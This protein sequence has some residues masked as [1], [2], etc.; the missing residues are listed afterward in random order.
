MKEH[1]DLGDLGSHDAAA[2]EFILEDIL[3]QFEEDDNETKSRRID[4]LLCSVNCEASLYENY[5]G[6]SMYGKKCVGITTN[7]PTMIIEQA[8]QFGILGAKLDS[9][10]KDS[11]VYWPKIEYV[12]ES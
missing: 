7:N 11:I 1:Y 3:Q 10:G 2:T 4:S 8:A 9:M 12:E 6:R 5:S